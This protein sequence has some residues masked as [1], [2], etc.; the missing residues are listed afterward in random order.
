M[1]C[2]S[3]PGAERRLIDGKKQYVVPAGD[4]WGIKGEGNSKLTSV[5]KCK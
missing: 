1:T 2:S 3:K 5:V 4:K